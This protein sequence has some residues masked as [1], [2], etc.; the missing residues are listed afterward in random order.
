MVFDGNF[1]E[2]NC[3]LSLKFVCVW[4][5]WIFLF[6]LFQSVVYITVRTVWDNFSFDLW[7][8]SPF[9]IQKFIFLSFQ[10]GKLKVILIG[11]R[12]VFLW[13]ELNFYTTSTFFCFLNDYSFISISNSL[14]LRIQMRTSN[15]CNIDRTN[16]F[17]IGIQST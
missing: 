14:W 17:L 5:A 11:K 10:W 12:N 1:T 3:M 13:R 16:W 6:S 2:T 15:N 9:T 4:I 7:F 8:T